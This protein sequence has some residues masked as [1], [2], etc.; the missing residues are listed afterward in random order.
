MSLRASPL[1]KEQRK[2]GVVEIIRMKTRTRQARL[3]NSA[4]LDVC[5]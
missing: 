4:L 1:S 2:K 5:Y 3:W